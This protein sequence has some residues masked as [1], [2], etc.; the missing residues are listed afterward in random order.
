MKNKSLFLQRYS[1]F[2]AA[3]I[4]F[5]I[6]GIC[7]WIYETAVTSYL[8]GRFADR[9]YLH[10]PVLPIYGVF[11]FIMLPVFKK[12]NGIFTVFFGGMAITTAL[13]FICSYLIEWIL[14]ESLWSYKSWDF[15]FEG[16]ISLYSSLAFGAMSVILIK[17]A[18]PLVIKFHKKAPFWVVIV[19]GT[20]CY[21]SIIIDFIYTSFYC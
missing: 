9:G 3:A 10:I 16:R 1:L 5:T 13:E 19:C 4:L 11:S 8:W 17:A 18:Y 7:G 20:A 6:C 12:H 2:C 15:N 14:D 21:L